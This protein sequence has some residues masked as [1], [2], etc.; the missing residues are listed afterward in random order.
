MKIITSIEQWKAVRKNG[1]IGFVPTMGAL[2]RGHISLVERARHEN[3]T[4]VVS[5]F[6]N[7]TQFNDKADFNTYPQTW[8]EDI[9]KLEKAD[10]DYVFSPKYEELYRDNYRYKVA[11]NE[12]SSVL[13]GESRPGHFDGVLTVVM[14]LLNIVCPTRAYFGKKDYQQYM[15]ICDMVEAFFMNI[16]IVGCEIIREEDGLAM[17]SRNLLLSNEQR[18]IAPQLHQIICKAT[19]TEEAKHMLTKSG[20]RVDYVVELWQRRFAAAFL[21]NVRLIDNIPL[22]EQHDSSS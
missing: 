16:E 5:I 17:S 22:G 19:S 13:C 3:S 7:P 12:M 14:K 15:L 21:G 9:A 2:H 1:D 6:V 10:I 18:V 4:C 11:E 8:E 20:F